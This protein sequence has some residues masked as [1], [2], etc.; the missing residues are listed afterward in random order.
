MSKYYKRPIIY[1]ISV[2]CFVIGS[3]VEPVS[4]LVGVH[5]GSTSSSKSN[6]VNKPK[7]KAAS[8]PDSETFSTITDSVT[9]S[10][11]TDSGIPSTIPDLNAH[12]PKTLPSIK[13]LTDNSLS[14]HWV[15]CCLASFH[16]DDS[17]LSSLFLSSLQ[18]FS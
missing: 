18:W 15:N 17:S 11:I 8:I 3:I 2:C 4:G 5:S 12:S 9:S 1:M 16:L 14:S 13:L 6:A 7:Q 10:T